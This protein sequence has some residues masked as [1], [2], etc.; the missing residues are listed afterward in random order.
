MQNPY[1]RRV[2]FTN[3]YYFQIDPNDS[4]N[5]IINSEFNEKLH[6]PKIK[7]GFLKEFDFQFGDVCVTS[8]NGLTTYFN[9][10]TDPNF[11]FLPNEEYGQKIKLE[12]Q[13]LK[14]SGDYLRRDPK[15]GEIT[16]IELYQKYRDTY[17]I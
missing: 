13:K 7:T 3:P 14:D 5:L 2:Q 9:P 17:Y 12:I 6:G 1:L 8:D 11:K 4:N 16:G 10:C 15:T